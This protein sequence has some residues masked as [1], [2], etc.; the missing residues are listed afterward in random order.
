M[1]RAR[2]G[3]LIAQAGAALLAH[4]QV[5]T[6]EQTRQERPGQHQ[7]RIVD[8]DWLAPFDLLAHGAERGSGADRPRCRCPRGAI[9]LCSAIL[10]RG[11]RTLRRPRQCRQQPRPPRR[12]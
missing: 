10:P 6:I 5:E 3:I 11:A 1:N 8:I 4:Q 7:A 12:R 2:R 9:L